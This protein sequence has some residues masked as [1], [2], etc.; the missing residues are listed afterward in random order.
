MGLVTLMKFC[1]IKQP[2]ETHPS[3]PCYQGEGHKKARDACDQYRKK[4]K[5]GAEVWSEKSINIVST[6]KISLASCRGQMRRY[7]QL[8]LMACLTQRANAALHLHY[9]ATCRQLAA[10]SDLMRSEPCVT[11]QCADM[12]WGSESGTTCCDTTKGQISFQNL[13]EGQTDTAVLICV[14]VSFRLD[15]LKTQFQFPWLLKMLC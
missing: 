14:E 11:S 7:S 10:T 2:S 9:V 5:D 15:P 12:G 8:V 3:D 4:K 6:G 1:G 13:W